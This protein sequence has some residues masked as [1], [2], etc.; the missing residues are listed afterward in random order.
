MSILIGSI[1]SIGYDV[2]GSVP[3][4]FLA[5]DGSAVSRTT[6]AALFNAI[7][8]NWGVGD[9]TST[10]NVPDTRGYFLRGVDDGINKDPNAA[11]RVANKNGGAAGEA[12]GSLQYYATGLP[13]SGKLMT[14]T[15]GAHTHD[16]PKLPTAS[17]WYFIAGSHYAAWNDGGTP[18]SSD[19]AHAHTVASGGDTETRPQ[20]LNVD[21]II[22]AGV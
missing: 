3:T 11:Q 4:G 18:T 9:G 19:G 17:S 14:S 6:Y 21:Y 5:C 22:Y 15:D 2:T 13:S 12:V 10:F 1:I 8:T 16:V 7:G 20:N